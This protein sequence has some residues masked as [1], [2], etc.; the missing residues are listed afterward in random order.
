M[1]NNK[2]YL[3][4]S[5]TL[6]IL[7]VAYTLI[8]KYVDVRAIGP[9][10]SEVGLSHINEAYRVLTDMKSRRKYDRIWYSYVGKKIDRQK[11]IFNYEFR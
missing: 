7:A 5:I 9:E 1:K 2:K 6:L 3:L 4:M 8:V 11:W 10:S